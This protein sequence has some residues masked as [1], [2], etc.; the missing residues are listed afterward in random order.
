MSV[1]NL[2]DVAKGISQNDSTAQESSGSAVARV[3]IDAGSDATEQSVNNV[4]DKANGGDG[5][6][7]AS[8]IVPPS[9][10]QNAAVDQSR[11]TVELKGSLSGIYTKALNIAFAKESMVEHIPA[12]AVEESDRK[13]QPGAV[14]E[15]GLFVYAV[16]VNVLDEKGLSVALESIDQAARHRRKMI[17][18]CEVSDMSRSKRLAN[19]DKLMIY[20]KR[21]GADIYVSRSSALNAI[22][23]Q[24]AG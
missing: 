5:Q 7:Q 22:R 3:G 24:M 10:E 1:F 14:G 15:D 4:L 16:D 17:V 2:S 19:A 23:N 13:T 9:P 20:A 18:A 21:A 11:Q 6:G 12:A 8:Q